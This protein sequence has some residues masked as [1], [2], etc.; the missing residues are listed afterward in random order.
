ML[1]LAPVQSLFIFHD[2][3]IADRIVG[4]FD[5]WLKFCSRGKE[6]RLCGKDIRGVSPMDGTTCVSLD[7]HS[8]KNSSMLKWLPDTPEKKKKTKKEN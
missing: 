6:V 1:L 8:L 7:K 4:L 5:I 2:H 3:R